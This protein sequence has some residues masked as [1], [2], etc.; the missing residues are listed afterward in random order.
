[1]GKTLSREGRERARGGRSGRRAK[2][3]RLE[4]GEAAAPRRRR[5]GRVDLGGAWGRTA[6]RDVAKI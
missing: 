2:W 3:K 6:E 5:P 4:R 1:M